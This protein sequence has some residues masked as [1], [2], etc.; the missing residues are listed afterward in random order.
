MSDFAV[1]VTFRILPGWTDAFAAL[2]AA[3]ARA[4]L[5]EPGC[6][7]FDVWHDPARPGEVFLYEIYDDA[8]A[9]DAH[10]ATRHFLS[11]DAKTRGMIADKSVLTWSRKG[12]ADA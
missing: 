3:Q 8:A 10:L 1:C 6:R 2:V 12:G 11:F 4:S 9:F 5:E 7:V